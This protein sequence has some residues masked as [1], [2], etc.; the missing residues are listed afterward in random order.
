MDSP[1]VQGCWLPGLQEP[2]V[3]SDLIKACSP[4]WAG[5][6]WG[7]GGQGRR[8]CRP[9]RSG[10]LSLHFLSIKSVRTIY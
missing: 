9:S 2:A 3:P 8:R 7:L 10:S 1:P 6:A 5:T 4:S